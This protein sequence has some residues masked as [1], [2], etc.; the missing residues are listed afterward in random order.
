M[1]INP[2]VVSKEEEGMDTGSALAGSAMG[3]IKDPLG[4]GHL[5]LLSSP[6][7]RYMK[8]WSLADWAPSLC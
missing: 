3:L 2:R 6:S 4:L 7:N 8:R 1:G 5:C